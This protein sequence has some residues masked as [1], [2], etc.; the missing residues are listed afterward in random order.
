MDERGERHRNGG[1]ST[2]ADSTARARGRLASGPR[3]AARVAARLLT[4]AL[5][6]LAVTAALGAA[7]ASAHYST[8][9]GQRYCGPPP[10]EPGAGGEERLAVW[11]RGVRCGTAV[12]IAGA[13]AFG[14]RAR[15]RGF[16]CIRRDRPDG[17]RTLGLAHVDFRCRRGRRVITF[18]VT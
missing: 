3:P 15:P 12:S 6:A 9:A 8:A 11:A 1:R 5:L 16:R 10:S 7:S 14:G 17:D 4:G 2:A 13:H 18:D